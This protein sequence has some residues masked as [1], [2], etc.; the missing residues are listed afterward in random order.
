MTLE[1]TPAAA[2]ARL[3]ARK[4]ADLIRDFE[5]TEAMPMT[6][7]LPI[8]RGWI[9]DELESRNPNAFWAWIDSDNDSPRAFF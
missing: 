1:A 4:T 9:M 8:I 2:K 6:A 5:L 3:S 7:E